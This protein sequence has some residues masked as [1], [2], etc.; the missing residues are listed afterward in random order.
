VTAVEDLDTIWREYRADSIGPG[1]VV[2]DLGASEGYFTNWA[3]ARGAMVDAYDARHGAAVGPYDGVC[4]VKG[5]GVHAYTVPGEGTTPMVALSSILARHDRVDF[6]KCD[7]EG[8]EYQ[9]FDCD[10][11]KVRRLAIEF[12]AWATPDAP[13]EGLMLRDE[14]M[15]PGAFDTLV[16][17]L[18]RTHDIEI[19]GDPAAGGYIHGVLR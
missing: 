12:H 14:P 9:I 2:V 5:D 18:Q 4:T 19:V 8:G 7:I 1:S 15:P 3:R 11:S 13:V 16:R 17:Q 6:L 10:L